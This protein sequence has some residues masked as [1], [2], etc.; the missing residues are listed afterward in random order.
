ME[1][2][3]RDHAQDMSPRSP[4]ARRLGARGVPAAGRE[5]AR[6]AHGLGGARV[7][8][9]E[10]SVRGPQHQPM[11]GSQA[12]PDNQGG[13]PEPP[14]PPETNAARG[15]LS[16]AHAL[17][18]RLGSLR[19]RRESKLRQLINAWFDRLVGAVTGGTLAL[20]P[21]QYAE[22][23]TSRDFLWN[24][25]GTV[26]WGMSFPVLTVVATQLAG[27]EQA[28][29][30]SLAYVT[31]ML[32]M[33][34][35][36][37]GV[38]TYQVSDLAEAHT[39]KDYQVHRVLTCL[40]MVALGLAYCA[41][42]GYTGLM[43]SISLGT[44]LWKMLDALADVYEGRLQQTDKLYLAGVSQLVRSVAAFAFFTVVLLV[45]RNIG[46]ACL[47]MAVGCAVSFVL[48]TLPVTL[49]ETP[50]SRR[51]SWRGVG[52]LFRQ[53]F[54]LF[55][56]LFL[57]MLIDSMPKFMMEGMLS[58]DNQLYYSALFIPASGITLGVQSVYKPLL[59]RMAS[60][61]SNRTKRKAFDLIIIAILALIVGVTVVT[62]LIM[63]W[64]GVAF[65]S[66]CYG[67]DFEQ[68]RGLAY[69]MV[70][71]GGVTAAIDFLYQ[72]ITL[73][74]R[75][76]SVTRIYLMTFGFSLYIPWLLIS[77]TELAG[78]VLSFMIVMSIL[79][80]LLASE[81]LSI[82][83]SFN[84]LEDA[85]GEDVAE[86][87][88]GGAPVGAARSAV[89]TAARPSAAVPEPSAEQGAPRPVPAGDKNAA[90]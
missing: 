82:R 79:F 14:E 29:M 17:L 10:E 73:L 56:A 46:V 8:D 65:L 21:A 77:F 50:R 31:G 2:R 13:L 87:V 41:L 80:V 90:R 3:E 72:V 53:C 16:A 27:A 39:F 66:F 4:V 1:Q 30:F 86:D 60:L 45:A 55:V 33:Y 34:V 18:A 6:P 5:G 24:T 76:K 81:Y 25:V 61:W 57:Y 88:A 20:E 11:R 89:G 68:Y 54:P 22:H 19:P 23:Q 37:Y 51:F 78:A 71:A 28:G 36:N 47:A 70:A 64:V 58:Y 63:S 12:S 43:F 59:V 7:R 52:D 15:P 49:F 40:A 48:F 9:A 83:T 38:R 85:V 74:R 62:M 32:L 75:Q 67:V 69:V 84:D 26:A 35:G 42:R 44:Y